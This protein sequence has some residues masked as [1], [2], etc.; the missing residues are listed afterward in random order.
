[1]GKS[2]LYNDMK[3]SI[4]RHFGFLNDYRFSKFKER[5][6][7]YEFHFETKNDFVTLDI[8]FESIASTPI[9]VTI[10][11]FHLNVLEPKNSYVYHYRKQLKENYGALFEQY[12][13]TNRSQYLE[14]IAKQYA[15]NGKELNDQYLKALSEILK[16]QIHILSGDLSLLKESHN[17]FE[18]A[19]ALKQ[20]E[21]RIKNGI[22][23]LEYQVFSNKDYDAFETFNSLS[24]LKQYVAERREITKYRVLDCYMNE[25]VLD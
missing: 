8:W 7:A 10:N 17:K 2:N 12:L 16:R 20:A 6:V 24:A 13:N 18:K 19:N 11:G 15:I 25:I 4:E 5:Q 23:T 1:M 14:A 9:W 21:K 22:Y 3:E